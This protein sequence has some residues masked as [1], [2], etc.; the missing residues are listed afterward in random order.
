L[1][2]TLGPLTGGALFSATGSWVPALVVFTLTSVL[3]LTGGR[4][5][6][7]RDRYLKDKFTAAPGESAHS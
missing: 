5:M 7:P 2:G 4:M 6:T 3:M 1:V